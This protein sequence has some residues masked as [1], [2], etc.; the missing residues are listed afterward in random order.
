MQLVV[1]S[2]NVAFDTIDTSLI[3]SGLASKYL[4]STSMSLLLAG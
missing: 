1:I 4:A 2:N 3:N